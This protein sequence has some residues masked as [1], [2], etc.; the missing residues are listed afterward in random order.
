MGKEKRE[1]HWSLHPCLN[2][3]KQHW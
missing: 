3:R 2:N 1:M